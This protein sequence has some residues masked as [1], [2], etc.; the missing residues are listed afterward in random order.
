MNEIVTLRAVEPE[1]AELLYSTENDV[2]AWDDGDSVAPYS[3]DMLRLYA[4]SYQAAP[5]EDGQ[6]RLMAVDS[7]DGKAVGIV[8]LYDISQRDLHACVA[9]YILP[10]MRGAGFAANAVKALERYARH[11]LLLEMLC[12]KVLVTNEASMHLFHNLGYRH[13]GTLRKWR[14]TSRGLIDMAIF[15]KDLSLPEEL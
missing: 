9:V 15:E 1:D 13:A 5:F 14:R 12:A 8:D 10:Q 6:V 7:R 2:S 4:A 3:M 11:A